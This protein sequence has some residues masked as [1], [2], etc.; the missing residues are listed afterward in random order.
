MNKLYYILPLILA[1]AVSM[2]VAPT[3]IFA[4]NNGDDNGNGN[5][6]SKLSDEEQAFQQGQQF[7]K[8][9]AQQEQQAAD[10]SK[11]PNPDKVK[12]CKVKAQIKVINA[13]NNT[14]YTVQL[15]NLTPQGKLANNTDTLAFN[16]QYKKGTAQYC[17]EKGSVEIGTVD[18]EQFAL[19]INS[20]TKPNKVAIDPAFDD[21]AQAQ[22]L[23]Q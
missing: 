8:Q 15:D 17:P 10:Q 23:Q 9:Q 21:Q 14:I 12:N 4:G 11:K 20:L 13:V 18:G 1:L 5:D 22:A 6:I 2:T 3:A 16:F 7:G 19:M